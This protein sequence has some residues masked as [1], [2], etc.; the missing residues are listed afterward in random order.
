MRKAVIYIALFITCISYSQKSF[1]KVNASDIVVSCSNPLDTNGCIQATSSYTTI[2]ATSSYNVSSI[3]YSPVIP[4]NQGTIVNLSKDDVFSDL[5]DIGFKFDFYGETYE[6]VVISENGIVSFNPNNAGLD[7]SWNIGGTIPSANVLFNSIFGVFHDLSNLSNNFTCNDNPATPENECGNIRIETIGTA[8]F[9]MFIVNYDGMT[10]FNCNLK[11]TTQI[12]LYETFNEIDVFVKDKPATCDDANEKNALLGIQNQNGTKA[13]VPPSRNTGDWAATNE[14]WNFKP[15]GSSSTRVEWITDNTV[16][17]TQQNPLLCVDQDTNYTVKTYYTLSDGTE[18]QFQDTMNLTFTNDYPKAVPVNYQRCDSDS[19]GSEAIDLYDL[20]PKITNGQIGLT[21]TFYSSK[22][23][24]ISGTPLSNSTITLNNTSPITYYYKLERSPGCFSID[25]VTVQM[26]KSPTNQL[27]TPYVLCDIGNNNTETISDLNKEFDELVKGSQLDVNISYH[28]TQLDADNN[29]NPITNFIVTPVNNTIYTRIDVNGECAISSP[30]Q[31]DLVAIPNSTT[32]TIPPICDHGN[33][34]RENYNFAQHESSIPGYGTNS[35][36]YYLTEADAE[37]KINFQT[38]PTSI[39]VNSSPFTVYVRSENPST[40]C[41]SI[42]T[43]NISFKPGIAENIENYEFD[44]KCDLELDGEVFNLNDAIP[45]MTSNPSKYNITFY[46]PQN[47]TVPLSGTAITNHI[48]YTSEGLFY[49]VFEDKITGCELK[50]SIGVHV[51]FIPEAKAKTFTKCNPEPGEEVSFS[52]G[53]YNRSIIGDQL[54]FEIL[55]FKNENDAI[56]AVDIDDPNAIGSINITEDTDVWIK[57]FYEDTSC[58]STEKIQLKLKNEIDIVGVPKA[59][60]FKICDFLNNNTETINLNNE[61]A[62]QLAGDSINSYKISY[63]EALNTDGNPIRRINRTSYNILSNDQTEIYAVT[64]NDYCGKTISK[65]NILKNAVELTEYATVLC[66]VYNVNLND[67]LVEMNPS[68]GSYITSYFSSYNLAIN[69]VP[70]DQLPNTASLNLGNNVFWVRMETSDG[71]YNVKKLTL[72]LVDTPYVAT[73]P[74]G[75]C[76]TLNDKIE[77]VQLSKLISQVNGSQTGTTVKFYETASDAQSEIN[78]VTQYTINSSTSLYVRISVSSCFHIEKVTFTF[79]VTTPVKTPVTHYICDNNA[80][81]TEQVNLNDLGYLLV[82]GDSTGY[83]YDFYKSEN[84]AIN[85]SGKIGTP[86]DYEVTPSTNVLY[87]RVFDPNECSNIGKLTIDFLQKVEA[88]DTP[89]KYLCDYGT[90]VAFDN[91]ENYLDEMIL[92]RSSLSIIYYTLHPDDKD[93]V[94][95]TNYT[96][97][98]FTQ[99]NNEVY[100]R[101]DNSATGCYTIRK[102]QVNLKNPPKLVNNT[103]YSKVCDKDLDGTYDADL[104]ELNAFLLEDYQNYTFSYFLTRNNANNNVNPITNETNFQVPSFPY[105][106]YVRADDGAC[107]GVVSTHLM[108]ND[109]TSIIKTSFDFN[110]ECDDDFDGKLNWNLTLF[111]AEFTINPDA[112]IEYYSSRDDANNE[113]NTIQNPLN[114]PVESGK[115]I[116]LRITEPN[117]CSIVTEVKVTLKP[118]PII[119]LAEEIEYCANEYAIIDISSM[120]LP[121][122][123]YIWNNGKIG[124]TIQE[125]EP[126]I[127]TVTVTGLNGCSTDKSTTIIPLEVPEI[128]ALNVNGNEISVTAIPHDSPSPFLYSIN[129]GAT[130]QSRNSFDGLEPGIYSI[131]VKSS[132]TGCISSPKKTKIFDNKNIITPGISIGKNDTWEMTDLDVFEG[133]NAKMIIYDRYGKIIHT[134]E[135]NTKLTWDGTYN[136]QAVPSTSYWYEIYLPDGRK[137]TGYIVVKNRNS[138]N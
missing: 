48:E 57:M 131:F 21:L 11:T 5:I 109:I 111:D 18:A 40:G 83:T 43:L 87:V 135:S 120:G 116:F 86:S 89:I 24:A 19:N 107:Q 50:R 63:Y 129:N 31:I 54:P 79:N 30:I 125:N 134:Q 122:A 85:E 9:R 133:K 34:S 8:P 3:N 25:S 96:N 100:V 105:T 71:C 99:R 76:D 92:D 68:Y 22:A 112:S 103:T 14:A 77:E 41:F 37:Q 29:R 102:I 55:W 108:P 46:N 2:Q 33:D 124:P 47:P 27:T 81:D 17:S 13:S 49:V 10:Q 97:Y 26:V 95:I 58:F 119:P 136:G 74:L 32:I 106:I 61:F 42:S 123:N 72:T 15:N 75:V 64:T 1:T 115:S 62:Q 126:G 90:G 128:T 52:L 127:Y 78:E 59:I 94:V 88:T 117:K 114:Y 73:N 138:S 4:Y 132:I 51:V 130:W 35:I 44:P 67:Y 82:Y 104:T 137:F 60:N 93:A 66:S 70:T 98:A 45:F 16:I 36:S 53:G 84:D 6:Q 38:R 113:Q 20:E 118:L 12:V 39:L 121:K 101:F 7:A 23:N 56:S 65:I 91:L 69:D 110:T 28:L 80:D